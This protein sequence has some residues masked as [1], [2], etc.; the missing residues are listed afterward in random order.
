MNNKNLLPPRTASKS[1]IINK[2]EIEPLL[3]R[4]QHIL[5]HYREVMNCS[6]T[7][8]DKE[9][10]CIKMPKIRQQMQ[11]C[12]EC[13]NYLHTQG[14]TRQSTSSVHLCKEA[15]HNAQME[16]RRRDETYI[17]TCTGGLVYWT[18][19]LYWN[20]HYA[21][22]LTAG[23]VL[24]KNG[25]DPQKTHSIVHERNHEEIQAMASLLGVCAKEVSE[26]GEETGEII[27]RSL[28]QG[29]D[30][31][32][33]GSEP[34]S[35]RSV[36]VG[37]PGRDKAKAHDERTAKENGNLP[38]ESEYSLE[39][40]RMLLA[41]FRRG[42]IDTGSG[43]IEEIIHGTQAADNGNM[44]S[45]RLRAIDLAVLLSRAAMGPEGSGWDSTESDTLL[46][47]N[48]RFLHR[49]QESKTIEELSKNLQLTAKHMAGRIF[50]F[51][52]KR[53]ACVLRKAERYIWEN[54]TRKISLEEISN[55]SGLSAPYFSSIFKEEMGENLSSYI[56]R[57]RIEK[58]AA[59]IMETRKPLTEIARLC[60]FEDQSWFSKTFKIFMGMSP[61][62]F[63]DKGNRPS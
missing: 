60:G 36:S 12:S 15:H 38:E 9:G 33:S 30:Q 10:S 63:R 3:A 47:A 56:N 6:A 22:A 23:Q 52:G 49:I 8:V 55:A 14:E 58:A 7:V 17:Y 46:E 25:K 40:E 39:K 29:T 41:A 61:G 19:P 1:S 21:G 45:V 5:S 51:K 2:R 57:L 26:K 34:A 18:S 32:I 50:S 42:D 27:R 37:R 43:I 54:Y 20:G 31:K 44:E 13:R 11:L 59:L 53:H 62:K 35:N 24:I 28:W 48:N 4:A 16:S